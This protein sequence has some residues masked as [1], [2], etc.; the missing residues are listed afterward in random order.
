M[1]SFFSALLVAH[2]IGRTHEL[3]GFFISFYS[4]RLG[5]KIEVGAMF[6]D[7]SP[8]S[9]SAQESAVPAAVSW[10]GNLLL[11]QVGTMIAVL[12]VAGF[13]FAILQGRLSVRDGV[14]VVMGCFILFGAAG[15]ARGLVDLAHWDSGSLS[16]VAAATE[17]APPPLPAPPT[18]TADP[19][20]GASVPMF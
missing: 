13:G 14:R 15:I 12:A 17:P 20:A 5:S 16:P 3:L 10:I 9:F 2:G 7:Q 6:M 8:A 4:E 1:E 18:P 11:G 19:Y